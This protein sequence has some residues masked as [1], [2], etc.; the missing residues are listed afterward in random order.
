MP[1]PRSSNEPDLRQEIR[2]LRRSLRIQ[3][4]GI[5]VLLVLLPITAVGIRP[6]TDFERGEPIRAADLNQRFNDLQTA[7]ADLQSE[8][9]DSQ[10]VEINGERY[11]KF[12]SFCGTGPVEDGSR[13]GLAAV[14]DDCETACGSTSARV[15][16]GHEVLAAVGAGVKMPAGVYSGA[17]VEVDNSAVKTKNCDEWTSNDPLTS[18]FRWTGSVLGREACD[19]AAPLLCCD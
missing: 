2:N 3:M 6:F 15:C 12:G 19:A 1:A 11:R 10:V 17:T 8:V 7:V 4:T 13:G 5:V 18:A 14:K 9:S 16:T